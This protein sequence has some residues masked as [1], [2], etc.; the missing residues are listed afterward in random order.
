[1]DSNSDVTIING[2]AFSV[3]VKNA[4]VGRLPLLHVVLRNSP[5]RCFYIFTGFSAALPRAKW[6][7]QMHLLPAFSSCT[8]RQCAGGVHYVYRLGRSGLQSQIGKATA[9]LV[10]S[11]TLKYLDLDLQQLFDLDILI[12]F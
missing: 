3:P 6:A 7:K 9:R 12:F 5:L 1:M 10:N 2:N 4:K 8:G 11:D